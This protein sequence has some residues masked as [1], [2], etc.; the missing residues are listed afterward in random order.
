M[1]SNELF[2]A[3]RTG[4]EIHV[5][6]KDVAFLSKNS[7]IVS[8]ENYEKFLFGVSENGHS[9]EKIIRTNFRVKD[10]KISKI[11][12]ESFKGKILHSIGDV[13][14]SWKYIKDIRKDVGVES[15]LIT[16][17]LAILQK[18]G[19]IK[20][21]KDGRYKY[22]ITP[23]GKRQ[24]DILNR[25]EDFITRKQSKGLLLEQSGRKSFVEFP[26]GIR[27]FKK[28]PEFKEWIHDIPSK[29][30]NAKILNRNIEL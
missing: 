17:D 7:M 29:N 13:S 22:T 19:F 15:R 30:P 23:L 8:I 9:F 5:T 20:R 4:N 12:P 24:L 1:I 2:E 18:D 26:S 6:A 21:V 25:Q 16:P 28:R 27:E 3:T 11:N 14:A 10:A